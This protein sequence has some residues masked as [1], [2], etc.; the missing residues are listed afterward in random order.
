MKTFGIYLS[1]FGTHC[2]CNAQ[3]PIKNQK[4][5]QQ[6]PKTPTMDLTTTREQEARTG[7]LVCVRR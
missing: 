1:T 3:K 6:T 4:S 5:Y 7:K 2:I